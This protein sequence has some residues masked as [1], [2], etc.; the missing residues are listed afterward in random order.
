MSPASLAAAARRALPL[1]APAGRAMG[2]DRAA[3]ATV[4][5]GASSLHAAL[6]AA[7]DTGDPA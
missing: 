4:R 3:P 6:L 2:P 5:L 1:R 7:L